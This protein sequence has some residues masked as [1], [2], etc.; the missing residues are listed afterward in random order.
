MYLSTT[1]Y[2]AAVTFL[3]TTA[4]LVAA[5]FLNTIV[6]KN[7]NAARKLFAS[8]SA[9]TFQNTIGN[10]NATHVQLLKLLAAHN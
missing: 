3:N 8:H 4:K 6:F 7:T 2:S 10:V 1:K 9:N 5:K